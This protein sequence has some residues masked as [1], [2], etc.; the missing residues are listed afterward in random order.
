M[1]Q[2]LHHIGIAVKDLDAAMAAYAQRPGHRVLGQRVHD[3]VQT[4]HV[5]F[6]EIAGDPVLLEL[7]APDSAESK[8]G[9]AVRKGGGLNH[10]CYATDDIEGLCRELRNAGMFPLQAPV[11]AV[12]FPGRRIAWLMGADGVPV[13][14]VEERAV[15]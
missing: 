10:L 15:E 9:S 12:A 8:L 1:N 5:A 6:I 4:A 13:E 2:R 3:Q 11:A 14:L 7:V